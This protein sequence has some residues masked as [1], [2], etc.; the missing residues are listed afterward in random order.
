MTKQIAVYGGGIVAML[1]ALSL[2]QKGYAPSL[3][4]APKN[5]QHVGAKR[6]FALNHAS[7][8][9]LDKLGI[10]KPMSA[11]IQKMYVWDS[12]SG[13]SI[14]LQAAD[15]Q[16]TALAYIVDENSLWQEIYQFLVK[17][18][19]P[20]YEHAAGEIP[21]CSQHQWQLQQGPSASFLCI[22]DGAQSIVREALNVRCDRDDYQQLG[23]V[24]EV[25][26]D[27]PHQGVAYQVFTPHGPLAFL[28]LP[29][30]NHYSMVWSL[31]AHVAQQHLQLS[32][33]DFLQQLN[34]TMGGQ[35]GVCLELSAR[36]AF[37]LKMLHTQAYVGKNWLLLG[38]SAHHF[39]PLA[40][41]GLNAGIADI[42]TLCQFNDPFTQANLSRFQR[43]RRAKISLLI[44]GMKALKQG[45]A[46]TNKC[47]VGLRGLG[48]DIIN[49]E[50]WLKKCMMSMVDEV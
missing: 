23:I 14:T 38:D 42:T 5:H 24:A 35:P 44:L 37:P 15:Q 46:N 25:I 9:V 27:K 4:R 8:V 6:V 28:P 22:A 43:E 13:A 50:R 16:K 33:D 11:A 30:P 32:A 21:I 26:C 36:H 31:D 49:N 20:L 18:S 48:M 45:F 7:M 10:P 41:L 34:V 2:A 1:T 29:T 12:L 19:I 17:T 3:W 47:W 39:H 40:G